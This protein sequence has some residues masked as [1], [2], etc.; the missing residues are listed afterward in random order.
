MCVCC[1]KIL[2][3]GWGIV[4]IY[5][6]LSIIHNHTVYIY[7]CI[8]PSFDQS[9]GTLASETEAR[10]FPRPESLRIDL[11]ARPSMRTKRH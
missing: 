8:Y 7:T 9:L 6:A 10:Y 3:V 5:K 2:W 4:K 11:K 1:A